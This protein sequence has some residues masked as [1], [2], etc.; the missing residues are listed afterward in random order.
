M[1]VQ[2]L[3]LSGYSQTYKRKTFVSENTEIV[4]QTLSYSA[5]LASK[6]SGFVT[7]LL[8]KLFFAMTPVGDG[9]L[10]FTSIDIQDIDPQPTNFSRR[11]TKKEEFLSPIL[12]FNSVVKTPTF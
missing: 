4:I 5:R 10:S 1:G 3:L 8:I 7:V 12:G 11:L 6:L 2:G 9:S